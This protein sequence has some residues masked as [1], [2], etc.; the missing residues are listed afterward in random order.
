MDID[1]FP[2]LNYI[3][4]HSKHITLVDSKVRD[5]LSPSPVRWY[6]D[7]ELK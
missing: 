2:P 5:H 3:P 7:E 4:S 6:T 1:I